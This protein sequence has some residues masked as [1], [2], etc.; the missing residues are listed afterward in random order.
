MFAN[1]PTLA[2]AGIG[3]MGLPMT[4]RL[5]A[6][7]HS[8]HVWNRNA[9]KCLPLEQGGAVRVTSPAELCRE[10][11]IVMLCLAD[12]AA[13]REVVFG[14]GGIV[15]GARAGQV[16]VDFSSLEPA[17]TR[18][19]AAELAARTGMRWVDAPVS[20]GTPGAEA[21]TLAIMA[22]GE[23][24][25]IERIRP[26]LAHLGQ[27]LTRMGDV[28]AGQVTKVCN[29]M[30]VACNALVIAEVVALAEKAGVDASL[31][32]P[33]LAGGFAD[34]KPLQILA[35]QMAESRF[36]PIK[37]HVRTLLKDLDTA[38]KLSREQ[39]SATP[40]SGLAAQL[41]RLHASQGHLEHDPATLV[42][43]YR[44]EQA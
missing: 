26:I 8:L 10:A 42:Q 6:A 43:Q 30:I 37:W 18:E 41:M 38:A 16:L 15:E 25:D 39:G 14:P 27:R 35:P 17:A 7:G 28:G 2:F 34:S 5:L 24:A 44:E 32:A 21:G 23:V 36:E 12:T 3:L 31:I 11:D 4:R 29:Q 20:G 19:M 9:D 40:M 13:V 33:A 1:L 22:G